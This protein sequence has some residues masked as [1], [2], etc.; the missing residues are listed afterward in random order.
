MKNEIQLVAVVGAGYWGRNLVRD[1]HSLGAAK[2][3]LDENPN[4]VTKML[5]DHPGL[6]AAESFDRVLKDSEV[7]GIVL[8]T[9]AETHYRLTRLALLAGKHVLV[10]KPLAL[11]LAE[12]RE[13]A[14]LAR[15]KGLVLMV[16]HL[17]RNHPA[18]CKLE[19]LTRGGDLG[20]IFH[21]HSRRRSFGKFRTEEDVLWSFGPHDI[22]MILGLMGKMPESVSASGGSWVT[23]GLAD[24]VEAGL[25]FSNGTTARISLSW[26]SPVKEHC[27]TVVGS[28]KMAVFDDTLP[29]PEKLKLYQRRIAWPEQR[30]TAESG[31]AEAIAVE[32]GSPL[33]RQCRD[34]LAAMAGGPPPVT[35]GDEGLG[36]LTVLSG[37]T[38]SLKCGGASRP[39]EA[40]AG[41][42]A[43]FVHPTAVVDSGVKIGSGCNIWHF[44]HLLDDT[45]LG[46]N[47]N[48]GQN[49]VVGPRVRV[50][51]GVKIQNNVSVY[52]GVTLEDDVFCGPSMVFT[53]VVNPRS[54]IVRKDE[55]RRTLVRRGASIG[56]NATIVCG[57][58]LG[59]W[60]FIGAGAVVTADVPDYALM[61]GAP[62]RQRG[63]ICRCGIKLPENLVCS[64]CGRTYRQN[65]DGILFECESIQA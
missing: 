46:E 55:Y 61:V 63:W 27:L 32:E 35:S 37:L 30:P 65:N 14:C 19:E 20:R 3:V 4:Q 51:R 26:F 17:L 25:F 41:L 38:A 24:E 62:A 64:Q 49:V 42:S 54:D 18:Y 47:C 43:Y 11:N 13:L 34:F 39:L 16:D 7:A 15:E 33:T 56:A 59:R 12:G 9:P 2:F 44:S 50:G 5:A 52:E 58:T 57:H 40:A 8:A 45:E 60:C 6:A 31:P 28:E 23:P 29:W 10:E 1:F 21:V 36:V 22:S 53:N 48:L